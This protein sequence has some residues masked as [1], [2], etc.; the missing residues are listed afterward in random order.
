MELL[1]VIELKRLPEI[2]AVIPYCWG[3]DYTYFLNEATC[4]SIEKI[5]SKNR[6][7]NLNVKKDKRSWCWLR[8]Y[9]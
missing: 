2:T 8:C 5:T 4:L 9:P 6:E 3:K 1:V 7:R